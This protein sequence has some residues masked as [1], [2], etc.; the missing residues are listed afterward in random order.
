MEVEIGDRNKFLAAMKEQLKVNPKTTALVAIDMH[1]GHL[2]PEVGSMLVSQEECQ[3]VLGNSQRLI[4]MVRRYQ[5]PII[6]VILQLRPIET[7]NRFN[8][9]SG[10]AS[11]VNAQLSPEERSWTGKPASK[12]G[13]WQLYRILYLFHHL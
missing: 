1:Q 5:I 2:D 8:P 12:D 10:P 4:E 13:W 9:F 3:R 6:H 7:R 11:L